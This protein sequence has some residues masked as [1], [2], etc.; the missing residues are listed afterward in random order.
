[1]AAPATEASVLCGHRRLPGDF[2]TKRRSWRSVPGTGARRAARTQRSEVFPGAV[3]MVDLWQAQEQLWRWAGR[4]TVPGR[5]CAERQRR[6]EPRPDAALLV[7]GPPPQGNLSGAIKTAADG[8]RRLS[9]RIPCRGAACVV[10][11]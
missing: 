3:E 5:R 11:R 10:D 6:R 4:S 1:M 8:V 2:L 7:A 9:P